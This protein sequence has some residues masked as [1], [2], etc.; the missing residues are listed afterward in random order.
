MQVPSSGALGGE[1]PR[2]GERQPRLGRRG[3]VRRP[4]DQPGH[5]LG[6]HVQHLGRRVPAR[7]SLGI[8]RE[9]R[10][11]AIP[12]V[13]KLAVLHAVH[14]LRELRIRLA[15]VL[16]RGEPGIAQRPSTPAHTA[17]DMLPHAD[18]HEKL[19]ILRPI[20]GALG[21]PDLFLAQGLAVRGA[22]V[23]LVGRT[24][25]DMAVHDDQRGP[26]GRLVEGAERPPQHV[27]VVGVA[28]PRDVPAVPDEAR[29]HVF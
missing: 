22:R 19:G 11:V 8:R 18:G 26:V 29:R 3:Q 20:V 5:V 7:E 2:V 16:Q 25:G 12:A 9:T 23:L 24:I 27:E 28:D 17:R 6:H 4:A 15:V 21:E 14:L 10:E 13:R 1:I